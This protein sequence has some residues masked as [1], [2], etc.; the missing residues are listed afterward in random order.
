M[1][2]SLPWSLVVL[3]S[4][5]IVLFMFTLW[6]GWFVTGV[7]FDCFYVPFFLASGPTVYSIAHY[8]Q[9]WS[10]HFFSSAASVFCRGALFRALPASFSVEFS[11]GALADCG[12]GFARNDSVTPFQ[13]ARKRV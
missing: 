10:E 3:H 8:V 12:S 6:N 4:A 5:L 13:M 11:G 7:P 9:H 1:K 2:L